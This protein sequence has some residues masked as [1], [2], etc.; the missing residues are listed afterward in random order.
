MSGDSE[1]SA[2]DSGNDKALAAE[3]A[4]IMGEERSM[5]SVWLAVVAGL[6]AGGLSNDPAMA[7]EAE[8]KALV[9]RKAAVIAG[10][11]KKSERP[12]V[13]A[14]QDKAFAA[15]FLAQAT[16][17]PAA[18]KRIDELNLSVQANFLVDEMC[19]IDKSG[20]EI[21][22]IVGNAVAPDEE[23]S[24]N[25]AENPFFKPS[26]EKQ[27]RQVHVTPIYISPDAGQWVVAYATPIMVEGD[28]KAILHYEH[29]LAKYQDELA[30]DV[31]GPIPYV[32]AVDAL[33]HVVV[34]TRKQPSVGKH[35][36][37]ANLAD[38]FRRLDAGL[39]AVVKLGGEGSGAF[40]EGVAA[41]K[42]VEDWTI[43]VVDKP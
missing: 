42:S 26:F 35:G 38:Y 25:E 2:C 17:R 18:K 19:L 22:R 14:A 32:L 30:R 11:H 27:A 5:R 33:G 20:K 3:A 34:D 8:A 1:A 21:S 29:S 6:V 40:A 31:P 39:A 43:V 28:K 12:L 10:M 15:Y 24:P 16:E 23:L 13:N 41:F 9:A 4:G 36:N 37:D 7:G